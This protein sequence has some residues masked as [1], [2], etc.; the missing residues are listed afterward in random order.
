MINPA[1]VSYNKE[2][3]VETVSYSQLI[4]PMIKAIQEHQKTI[5]DL[6]SQVDALTTD[7]EMLISRLESLEKKMVQTGIDVNR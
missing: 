2:G 4:S 1:F 3:V 7:R 6:K 5:S